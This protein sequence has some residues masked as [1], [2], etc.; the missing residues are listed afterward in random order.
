M[1]TFPC[2][3][4]GCGATAPGGRQPWCSPTCRRRAAELAQRDRGYFA[5]H[6]EIGRAYARLWDTVRDGV[7]WKISADLAAAGGFVLTDEQRQMILDHYTRPPQL[8]GVTIPPHVKEI[9][10]KQTR[11]FPMSEQ[12]A[13]PT[14]AL[15][16]DDIV[17]FY[18]RV[19]DAP[20]VASPVELTRGQVEKLKFTTLTPRSVNQY[21][22]M[23][24]L[25]GVPVK[26]VDPEPET[27][28]PP[29]KRRRW[30]HRFTRRPA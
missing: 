6:S 20:W 14:P 17:S 26:I 28:P 25:W 10:D 15:N 1:T 16:Y 30:W 21:G 23:P 4:P 5:A 12:E 2:C 7:A 22:G 24:A 8:T 11:Q 18:Q 13:G 9:I 3:T 19:S 29:P 27:A